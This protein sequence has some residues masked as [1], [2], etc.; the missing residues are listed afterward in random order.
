MFCAATVNTEDLT[1]TESQSYI[2]QQFCV[3]H[4]LGFH[5]VLW[6]LCFTGT[7]CQKH[8]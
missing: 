5:F 8:G 6:L 2:I 7:F 4:A 1:N 3:N